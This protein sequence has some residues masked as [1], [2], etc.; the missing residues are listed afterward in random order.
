MYVALIRLD[1]IQRGETRAMANTIAVMAHR[2][3][4]RDETGP[5]N[6]QDRLEK[7]REGRDNGVWTEKRTRD[8]G[9]G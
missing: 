6:K 4:T 8:K 9:S 5:S 1:S 7:K 3:V 2:E